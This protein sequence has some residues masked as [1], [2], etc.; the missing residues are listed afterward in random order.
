MTRDLLTLLAVAVE[1]GRSG[2]EGYAADAVSLAEEVGARQIPESAPECGLH[3]HFRTY[4]DCSFSEKAWVHHL[5]GGVLGCDAGGHFSPDLTPFLRMLEVWPKQPCASQWQRVLRNFGY[6]YLLPACR[7]NPF[8]IAPLGCF[9]DEGL[10][11]FAGLWHGMNA[12]YAL[13]A[14]LAL[15]L[16]RHFG[17]PAFGEL[18]TGN[19]QWIAG[20]NAGVTRAS[21][22]GAH[23]FSMDVPEELALPASM[24]CGIGRRWAGTWLNVRG[25]ICN[26]FS[27]GDQFKFDV[28]PRREYDGPHS[29]TDEDWVTHAGGWLSALARVNAS[30]KPNQ[31]S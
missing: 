13:T 20:L 25:A 4:G 23:M 10:I 3:G 15:D 14:A 2:A 17:D 11:H 9:G 22:R 8:G 7:A 16:E 30:R 26:G 31:P 19:L 24:I 21:L 12:V 29:F 5:D 1:L 27:T 6:G 18:A 28:P